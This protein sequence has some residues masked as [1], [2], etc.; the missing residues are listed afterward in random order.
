MMGFGDAQRHTLQA[1][2]HPA[3]ACSP[4]ATTRPGGGHVRSLATSELR[5]HTVDAKGIY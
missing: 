1:V 4:R 3:R 2:S 5:F